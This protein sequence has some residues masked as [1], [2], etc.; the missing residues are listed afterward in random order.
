MSRD[1]QF[2]EGRRRRGGFRWLGG[3]IGGVV[4]LLFATPI[5]LIMCYFM[6]LVEIPAYH[7]AVLVKRTG[8]DLDNSQ[9]IAPGEEFKG[10]QAEVLSS[11]G[12]FF[13]NPYSWDW[14]VVKQI[15]IPQGKL[16]VLVRLYGDD[17]GYG[18]VIAKDENSKGIVAD[19]L[20]PGRY[21]I[22]AKIINDPNF[23]DRYYD[24]YAYHIE[25]HDPV[26]VPAGFKG[27]VTNLSGPMP[28]DPNV[29]L[30]ADG[31]RGVQQDALHPGTYYIN[32]YMKRIDLVDCRSQRFDLS[33]GGEMGF[34]SKDGFWVTLDGAIEFRVLPDEAAR[35]LVTYN[36]VENDTLGSRTQ[37]SSPVNIRGRSGGISYEFSKDSK[38]SEHVALERGHTEIKDEIINKIILPNARSFCR[39]RGS[40]HSGK[41]F[42][43][44][45]TRIQF[46]K[47]FEDALKETCSRQGV[48]VIQAVITDIQP[49]QK[50]AEP[51]RKRQIAVL[52]E[53]QYEKQYL[54]QE[55][56]QKLAVEKETVKQKQALVAAEQE[57]VK[58]VTDA[59]RKQEVAVIEANQRLA[60]AEF[61][62]KAAE[63]EAAAI[64]ARGKAAADVIMFDNEA[65]A[66]GWKK[67]VEAFDGNGDEYARWVLLRK[68]APSFRRM[69]VNTADSP[70]MEIFKSYNEKQP[71]QNVSAE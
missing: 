61:Q 70:M 57:V 38:Q 64:A 10:V 52:T 26:T 8:K 2:E 20:R 23:R 67:A 31:D 37:T 63:D 27:V 24:S 46:Q 54:Q 45:E 25:L 58:K 9:E 42:I 59:K 16:G 51:V 33:A 14:E 11:E 22:N 66:A 1:I 62:L 44:G 28:E 47:D 68:L 43:S 65:E 12:R 7:M 15:E 30:V 19:V 4:L 71:Q 21:P 48:E 40:N 69:M 29:L 13:Y 41:D 3:A 17:L 35:V 34:P 18:E 32:P 56:E 6:C 36:E 53:T 39:L 50:I 55:S 60:V 49:P 5:L